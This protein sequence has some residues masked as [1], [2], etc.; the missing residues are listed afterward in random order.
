MNVK[1]IIGII[2]AATTGLFMIQNVTVMELRG[3]RGDRRG[4]G[5][6]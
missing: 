2:L 6:Y 1:L 4:G 5:Q 3:D